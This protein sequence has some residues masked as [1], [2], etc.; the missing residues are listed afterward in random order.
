MLARLSS[1]KKKRTSP[2]SLL[3]Q[4]QPSLKPGQPS[5]LIRQTP[6]EQFFS[7]MAVMLNGPKADGREFSLTIEFTDLGEVHTLE[8]ENA[9]LHH[10][11]GVE[12]PNANATVRITHPLFINMLTG[13]AGARDIL[14]SDE[15]S[16][17]GSKLEL[18]Q[19]FALLDRPD[20]AFNIV[21][22]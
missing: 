5:P 15:V 10:R 6:V 21:T 9:V 22:P 12:N 7:V 8:L 4:R 3:R 13:R 18:L 20:N 14:F 1:L 19:F 11:A 2:L 17:E 16:V